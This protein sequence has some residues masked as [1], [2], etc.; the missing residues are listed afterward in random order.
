MSIWLAIALGALPVLAFNLGRI[1]EARSEEKRQD[2]ESEKIV[3]RAFA[4]G[5]IC[6]LVENLLA[7]R[8]SSLSEKQRTAARF[9]LR[10]LATHR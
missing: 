4:E 1:L 7:D 6:G 10:H 2:A 8:D 3:C 5:I 9:A